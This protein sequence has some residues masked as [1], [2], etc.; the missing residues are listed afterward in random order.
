MHSRQSENWRLQS[1]ASQLES[2]CSEYT[3][4]TSC[5]SV[6]SIHVQHYSV[7]K[8]SFGTH[9]RSSLESRFFRN[10]QTYRGLLAMNWSLS[11]TTRH[12]SLYLKK[13]GYRNV[14]KVLIR[15][16]TPSNSVS[17]TIL[18]FFILKSPGFSQKNMII[19]NNWKV[20]VQSNII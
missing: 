18:I 16:I 9:P 14:P 6:V 10:W 13:K 15:I 11:L 2:A 5:K 4:H 17:E 7:I 20:S 3:Q 1:V 19:E 12:I 8:C